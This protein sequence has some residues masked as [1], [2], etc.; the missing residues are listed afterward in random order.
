MGENMEK[1]VDNKIAEIK[2]NLNKVN[3]QI[4]VNKAKLKAYDEKHETYI[5]LNRNLSKCVDL[6]RQSM[7]GNNVEKLFD[8]IDN[9]N[10]RN[11]IKETDDILEQ[12]EA[13]IK[14]LRNLYDKKDDLEK[15]I[16]KEYEKEN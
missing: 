5:K 14:E 12:K 16:K 4:D 9:D 2:L 13:T 8:S 15:E 6:L 10:Y 3:R 1:D 11:L 7:E